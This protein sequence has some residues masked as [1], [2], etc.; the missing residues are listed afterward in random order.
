[1]D[2]VLALA[3][4]QENRD[5]ELMVFDWNKAIELILKNKN[6]EIEAGLCGDWEWTG[7]LIFNEGEIIPREETYTYLAS[8]WATPQ[9]RIDGCDYDCYIMESETNWDSESYYPDGLDEKLTELLKIE[10]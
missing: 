4:G 6:S 1:M 3:M 10:E 7:G 8:L 9:I 2:T 5:K